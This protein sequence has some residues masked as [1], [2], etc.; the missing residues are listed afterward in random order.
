MR[1]RPAL[2]QIEAGGQRHQVHPPR[3]VL[4]Q[5]DDRP[6]GLGHQCH[7]TADNG[8]DALVAGLHA[9][10]QRGEHVVRVGQR[11]RR[12]ARLEGKAWQFAYGNGTFQQRMLGMCAKM[13]ESGGFCGHDRD[14]IA[15]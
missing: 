2:A 7:L 6:G 1:Q 10:F 12:H 13:D 3:L 11:D 9:E 14:S 8:L 5:K 4:C 15:A